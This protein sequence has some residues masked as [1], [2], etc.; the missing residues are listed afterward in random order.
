MSKGDKSKSGGAMHTIKSLYRMVALGMP[1]WI[2]C[3]CGVAV[4]GLGSYGLSFFL[5]LLL[6]TS[7]E[8]FSAGTFA[9][10]SIAAIFAAMLAVTIILV[11]GYILNL[12]GAMSVRAKIQRKLVSV[13]V[14]LTEKFA[15][16]RHSGEAMTLVT[17]DIEVVDNFY[18]QGLMTIFFIPFFQGVA[19]IVTFITVDWQLLLPSLVTGLISLIVSM[20]FSVNVQERNRTLRT[21]ADG[22]THSFSETV[23]SN[24]TCRMLGTTERA[25]EEYQGT[26]DDYAAKA[27]SAKTI[28]N[29]IKFAVEMLDAISIILF[30]G[31]GIWKTTQGSLSLSSLM[32][33][34]PLIRLI[35]EFMNCF[36]AT[37][38]FIVVSTT[39]G[40][41]IID[42]LNWPQEKDSVNDATPPEKI[43]TLIFDDVHF[44]YQADK[45]VL[46]GI[47]FSLEKGRT[48]ALVGGSGG[49]KSTILQ[50]LLRFYEPDSGAITLDGKKS[51]EFTLDGWRANFVYLQQ[52]APLLVKS[53]RENIAMGLYGS[54]HDPQDEEII[55]AAKAAGAHQFIMEMPEGY[56][57]IIDER[58]GNLSGGQRQRI[59]IARAFLSEAPIVLL[60][61]PTAALD[62]ESERLVQQ[63]LDALM[64]ERT[65]VVVAHRLETIRNADL[66]LVLMEGKI[67][68]QGDHD[69]LMKLNGTYSSLYNEQ[70]TATP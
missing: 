53:V 34:F 21:A 55:K 59:A 17:S 65:V 10:G 2:L 18:F 37:W 24:I 63:S 46:N 32:L 23:G 14:R 22:M 6:S 31:I 38:N 69:R 15:S 4:I 16:G 60:D 58:G 8:H 43:D 40:E 1:Q 29:H 11:L 62:A 42:A 44:A 5:G 7:L 33:V 52:D 64:R 3:L 9:G 56:D 57:S 13:W 25:L 48:V 66:I 51:D 61:E 70:F 49:G 41:R 27:I 20:K 50:L 36:G 54:G 12:H 68:E 30:F 35:S 19:T 28:E 45:P 47:S 26:S 67:V 39:S